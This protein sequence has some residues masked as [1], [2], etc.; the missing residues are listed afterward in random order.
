[1]KYTPEH[2]SLVVNVHATLKPLTSRNVRSTDK[3]FLA[4]VLAKRILMRRLITIRQA[5][6]DVCAHVHTPPPTLHSV[7]FRAQGNAPHS[8]N[9][10]NK[11]LSFTKSDI[12]IISNMESGRPMKL[13]GEYA[14]THRRHTR[15]GILVI[16]AY[17][18]ALDPNRKAK[19]VNGFTAPRQHPTTAP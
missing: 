9:V 4:L 2:S 19:A 13:F 6:V 16:A 14:E 5:G 3:E 12:K 15:R 17:A 11:R 18:L 10:P 8:T 7:S 1:M